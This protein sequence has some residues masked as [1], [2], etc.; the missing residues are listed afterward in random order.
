MIG[1]N[2]SF[3]NHAQSNRSRNGDAWPRLV[4]ATYAIT[5]VLQEPDSET[6]TTSPHCISI[7]E[8]NPN[9]GPGFLNQ[10]LKSIQTP[11]S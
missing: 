2:P 5:S 6:L 9:K 11:G 4:N 3:F 7:H 8:K 10:I 1:I